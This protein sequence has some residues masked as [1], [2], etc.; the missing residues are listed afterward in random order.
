MRKTISTILVLV[1]VLSVFTSFGVSAGHWAQPSIDF[2]TQNGYW[3]APEPINPDK[4]ATRAETASLF[5][6]ALISKIPE[7]NG[8]FID[9]TADN[10]YGGDITAASLMGLV[11]GSNGYFR[12]FDSLTREELAC[13][14]DRAAKMI[15][16]EFG[17]TEWNMEF[18][19]D[20]DDVSFWANQSVQNVTKYVLMKGKGDKLF[21]PKGI[22][23]IGEVAT[24]IAALIEEADAAKAVTATAT[25]RDLNSGDDIQKDYDVLQSGGINVLNGYAGYGMMVRFDGTPGDIYVSR[26]TSGRA[27]NAH[28]FAPGATVVKVVDPNGDTLIRENMYYKETGLMEKIIN[29]PNG[30]PGIYRITFTTG[31]E[32][33]ICTI[34]VKN[35][36]SWGVYG[37]NAFF[38]TQSTPKKGY[39]YMPELHSTMS[40]GIGGKSA[41]ATLWNEAGTSRLGETAVSN[42]VN[43]DVRT[44]IKGMAGNAVYMLEVPENFTGRLGFTGAP[45]IISPTA[46]MAWDLKGG[47]VYH[48]D[49]YAKLQLRHP[50]AVRARERM[51]EIYD[52]MGGDF[53]V[54][55]TKPA[56]KEVYDNPQAEAQLHARYHHSVT[57]MKRILRG[58]CLDPTNPYFGFSATT[59]VSGENEWPTENWQHWKMRMGPSN[60]T[61]GGVGALTINAETN[62]YYA[63][64]VLLKRIELQWLSWAVSMNET[65]VQDPYSP[66][67]R[68]LDEYFHGAQTFGL[69]DHS[70]LMHGYGE[71]RNWLSPK[72]RAICDEA[73]YGYCEVAMNCRGQGANNQAMMG[74][75]AAIDA[76][77]ATGMQHFKDD[78]ERKALGAVY[79]SSV[80][81]YIG[82]TSPLGYWQESGGSD[83]NNYGR[84]SE[85]MYDVCF[86]EYLTLPEDQKD[87]YVVA[88]MSAAYERFAKFDALFYAPA[89][90]GFGGPT[91]SGNYNTNAFTSREPTP[92]GSN[93]AIP[94]NTYLKNFFPSAMRNDFAATV[95]MNDPE[96]YINESCRTAAYIMVNDVNAYWNIK[97][98]WKE[99]D[100]TS[101]SNPNSYA[102]NSSWRMYRAF[103]EPRKFEY[104]DLPY[105]PHEI[106]GDYNI[107]DP[108]GGAVAIKHKGLYMMMFYDNDLKVQS[109]YSWL[110]SAPSQIWDEYFATILSSQKPD[111]AK[112][113]SPAGNHSRT[114]T[115]N[116]MRGKYTEPEI[117]L[118]GVEGTDAGGQIF[119]EGK[120]RNKE[121]KWIEEGKSF[122]INGIHP[123]NGSKIIWRYFMT[124]EGVEIEAGLDNVMPG[125][126]LYVQLPLIDISR[127][128]KESSL[129]YSDEDNKVVFAHNDKNTTISWDESVESKFEAK[130][131]EKS[132][133]RFLKL[134]IT[135]EQ[136]MV[137]FKFTREMGDYVFEPIFKKYKD[138]AQAEQ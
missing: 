94:G 78:F 112:N 131:G 104:K 35:P 67:G 33:D 3:I 56:L 25:S 27:D 134:K 23:T 95:G 100:G 82:Q 118:V 119:V 18:Y 6:R 122:E 110:A 92:Y 12:P 135:P 1:M 72:T 13:I 16:E 22:V 114:A 76:Y 4:V 59:Y 61:L 62:A 130:L 43:Y 109:G 58:L 42:G 28:T 70:G 53:T 98:Y 93:S 9:V 97:S 115:Q 88:Q 2:I 111:N 5:A 80:P 136:P 20:G 49:K 133:Y 15:S 83:G 24:V 10:I 129:T 66:E 60:S 45:K 85:G 69:G 81:N 38:Y 57:N 84:M 106:P 71:T 47:I 127:K 124:D 63:N 7:Y 46:E 90:N 37:E 34:G 32:G 31:E 48:E 126:D 120:E 30:E 26:K 102:A 73:I 50:I 105:L 8:A 41:K 21:D 103:H 40:I 91:V 125:S 79:P 138:A 64:P 51:V 117:S 107:Y 11:V 116:D 54:N 68:G 19:R 137:R 121:F 36:V 113:A 128:V 86:I 17:N 108:E 29:I 52:E 132:H 14:V 123:F 74:M 96:T 55:V 87:P 39:I 101:Y 77:K 65:C 75:V 99:Y 89:I 44:D